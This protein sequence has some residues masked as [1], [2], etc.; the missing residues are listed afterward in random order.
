MS[1][2]A[3]V[4]VIIKDLDAVELACE[5]LGVLELIRNQPRFNWY[6][7]WVNDYGKEDAA[8]RH[9]S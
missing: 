5:D 2:V 6:G 8:Y 1:H 9:G 7:R 4:D 3:L